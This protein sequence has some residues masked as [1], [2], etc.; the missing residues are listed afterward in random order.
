MGRLGQLTAQASP[1]SV[2][3]ISAPGQPKASTSC[4]VASIPNTVPRLKLEW[5]SVSALARYS[6]GTHLHHR[7]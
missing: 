1:S 2:K 3:P 6:S 7:W 4:G 5:I